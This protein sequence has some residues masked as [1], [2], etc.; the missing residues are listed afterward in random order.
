MAGVAKLSL[1][2]QSVTPS[3]LPAFDPSYYAAGTGTYTKPT[4]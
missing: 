4:S 3:G 2:L 1:S